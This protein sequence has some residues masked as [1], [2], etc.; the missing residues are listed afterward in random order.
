MKLQIIKPRLSTKVVAYRKT[1]S[2]D[3]QSFRKDVSLCGVVQS[4][5]DDLHVLAEDL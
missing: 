5:I 2:I 1:R 4:P 3:I